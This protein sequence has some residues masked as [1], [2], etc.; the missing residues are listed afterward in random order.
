MVKTIDLRNLKASVTMLEAAAFQAGKAQ[1]MDMRHRNHFQGLQSE[2]HSAFL[3]QLIEML[4]E[5]TE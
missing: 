5:D 4:Q 2:A 3:D 1:A